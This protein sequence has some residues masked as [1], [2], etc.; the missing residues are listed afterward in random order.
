MVASQAKE[1]ERKGAISKMFH[2]G[3]MEPGPLSGV[4]DARGK[5]PIYL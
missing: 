3:T 2:L 1:D 5:A 4:I